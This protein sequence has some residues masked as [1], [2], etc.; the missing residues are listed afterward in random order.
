MAEAHE[1]NSV[2]S[3]GAV[4]ED[5]PAAAPPTAGFR[6]SAPKSLFRGFAE[7]AGTRGAPSA[8]QSEPH[9]VSAS[10]SAFQTAGTRLGLGFENDAAEHLQAQAAAAKDS[11]LAAVLSESEIALLHKYSGAF[12]AHS[13]FQ[14]PDDKAKATL[15][16][17]FLLSETTAI[18]G[19]MEV[20]VEN[21]SL[22]CDPSVVEKV[23]A[24]KSRFDGIAEHL[25]RRGRDD[26]NPWEMIG[27]SVFMNRAA[28]KIASLDAVF[29][30]TGYHGDVARFGTYTAETA[31]FFFADVCSGP[32]GFSEYLYYRLKRRARGIGMT[33]QNH[34]NLAF[35]MHKCSVSAPAEPSFVDFRG[36]DGTGDIT[37]RANLLALR[38]RVEEASKS[39]LCALVTADG[40]FDVKS[41][42]NSQE[43][44]SRQLYLCQ[45]IAA[46]ACLCDGG[47]FVCKYFDT[48]LEFTADLLFLLSCCFEELHV[49]KPQSSRPANSER[50]IV[51]RRLRL[52]RLGMFDSVLA[53]MLSVNDLF[54]QLAAVPAGR[55]ADPVACLGR[56]TVVRFLAASSKDDA[57]FPHFL[58]E[59]NH[60]IARLQLDCLSLCFKFIASASLSI[61]REQTRLRE[62][63]LR[64]WRL[65]SAA[66][67]DP[68]LSERILGSSLLSRSSVGI[69]I[70]SSHGF[71]GSR[72]QGPLPVDART[73]AAYPCPSALTGLLECDADHALQFVRWMLQ[74]SA[75]PLPATKN[76]IGMMLLLLLRKEEAAVAES[77]PAAPAADAVP[78]LATVFWGTCMAAPTRDLRLLLFSY[79][80]IIRFS[81]VPGAACE[82]PTVVFDGYVEWRSGQ[83]PPPLLSFAAWAHCLTRKGRPATD[84][85]QSAVIVLY[86]VI[87]SETRGL[88]ADRPGSRREKLRTLASDIRQAEKNDQR[89][90]KLRGLPAVVACRWES[91]SNAVEKVYQRME[92]N[93]CNTSTSSTSSWYRFDLAAGAE[94]D[95]SLPLQCSLL[96]VFPGDGS[97]PVLQTLPQEPETEEQDSS[98]EP[99]CKLRKA[100]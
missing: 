47:D 76:S 90:W 60:C 83:R 80:R 46:I 58:R 35:A 41:N 67:E 11:S 1:E 17:G 43:L 34:G 81:I 13:T 9:P 63:C 23:M 44:L 27:K 64:A 89:C 37:V 18:A 95:A 38:R 66:E 10:V 20:T 5:M 12:L 54:A 25:F 97:S 56:P 88:A 71:R 68:F 8:D 45:A 91:S 78:A 61:V 29:D 16:R 82:E 62:E 22:F 59:S 96:A 48:F 92:L 50:F 94:L 74:A 100:C 75:V 99:P 40:G 2:A 84:S 98:L 30:L 70:G 42:E 19:T 85:E 69:G 53:G 32:G 93:R 39:S 7:A 24:G 33:L 57:A 14:L 31:P 73:L 15:E 51:C 49:A 55:R 36:A 87:W 26:G 52:H 21:Q 28:V 72:R 86:D 4:H 3:D 79:D 65:P 6:L 77:L